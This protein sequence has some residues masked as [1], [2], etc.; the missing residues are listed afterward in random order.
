MS[1]FLG[2]PAIQVT[3]DGPVEAAL[4]APASKSLTNR[5]ILIAGLAA[6]TSTLYRPLASQDTDAMTQ[7]VT[8]LGARVSN[9]DGDLVI[10]GVAGH[11]QTGRAGPTE[12]HAM[13]S[14]T[15]MRFGVAA[16]ALGS[17]AITI[18]GFPPLLLRPIGPL[19]QA[20]RAMGATVI[21]AEG[22][23]PV[24][25]RGPLLGGEITVD[26]SGSSQYLSAILLAA[27]YARGDVIVSATGTAADAYIDMTIEMMR[28]WGAEVTAEGSRTWYVHAGGQYHARAETIEYDASAAAHLYALA[29]ASGG[30]VSVTN[31][32]TSTLQPD[33]G[34][35]DVLER[36]GCDVVRNDEIVTVTGPQR[37]TGVDV[38]LHDMP[39]QL[40]T[41]AVLAA[42]AEGTTDISGAAVARGHETDRI[43]AVAKELA[44]LGV[45]VTEELDGLTIQGG[46]AAGPAMLKTYHDHRL[47]MAFAALSLRV[48]H[49]VIDDPGCVAKTYPGF[50]DDLDAAGAAVHPMTDPYPW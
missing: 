11:V 50:W 38:D 27:P 36:M 42:L 47:A 41:V 20:L 3:S 34:I 28:R 12:I 8:G 7:L 30:T 21:D 18:S 46:G 16:A 26:V 9:D 2:A 32:S 23:P 4:R 5:A 17:D 43:A 35:L 33:A 49:L 22:R 6:G 24:T 15:T 19:T 44:K 29:A 45:A 31:V 14:G 10:E 39:D 25:V 1:R 48:P 37:L 40:P 13:L